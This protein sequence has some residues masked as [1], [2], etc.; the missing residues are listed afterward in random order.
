MSK[1]NAVRILEANKIS[2]T[3]HDYQV[4]ENDLGGISVAEKIGA[5]ADTV[6]K[7]LVAS[8]DKT[9]INV[10]CV[11]VT[12]EL[13]LKKAAAASGNKKIEML[14]VKDLFPVTGYVR[15]GCSPVGMKKNF[16]VY[17]DETIQIFDKIYISAG[18]RGTQVCIAPADLKMV[19]NG[20]FSD[21]I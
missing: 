7:T 19:T 8:G 11:P 10:F 4:D 14:R 20:V 5:D 9:G 12:A 21:L 6:F 15:G 3:T 2:F 13:N 1:T 16:P 18:V 17:I